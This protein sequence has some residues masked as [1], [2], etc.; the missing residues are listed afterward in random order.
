[1]DENKQTQ[2][3]TQTTTQIQAPAQTQA[4]TP[5]PTDVPHADIPKQ[6]LGLSDLFYE[7]DIFTMIIIILTVLGTFVAAI[8]AIV[9][10][11]S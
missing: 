2:T 1:M 4:Q 10:A 3:Q 11:F 8:G 9:T 6:K 5:A 7:V